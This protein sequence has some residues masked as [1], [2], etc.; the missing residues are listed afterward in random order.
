MKKVFIIIVTSLCIGCFPEPNTTLTPTALFSGIL[1]H[2]SLIGGSE[3]EHARQVIEL[4]DGGIAIVGSTQSH[5]GDFRDRTS[6]DWDLF[7]LKMDQQGNVNWQKN[8]G[9]SG[10]D[11]GYSLEETEEGGFVL[12]GYSNSQDGDVPPTNGFH[13]N[14]IIKVDAGGNLVWKKTFGFSGHDHA[15][16][17]ISTQDGGYFFNGFLD[18]TASNGA[19]NSGGT[20]RANR[21]GVGEF[22]CHK[23]DAQGNVEWQRY[24]GGTNNDRSYDALQ[25]KE[26]NFLVVGTSESSDV[27][28]TQPKGSYDIWVVMISPYGNL[29][30]ENS[31]GGSLVDGAS[32]VIQDSQGNFRIIGNTFSN[33][34]QAREN[35]GLSDAW[36]IVIDQSGKL[37]AS[38]HYGGSEFDTG[39]AIG[40]QEH[41]GVF[42]TGHSRSADGD[43]TADA[44]ENDLFLMHIL[45]GDIRAKAL[46]LGGDNDDFAYDL[47]IHSSGSVF[48]VGQ[49]YSSVI[50][51]QQNRGKGDILFTRWR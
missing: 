24:F 28:V 8:Y 10:D 30:W 2:V 29:L 18:V 16:K 45:S 26:G 11:F 5:D 23:L 14:W 38:H 34:K 22:W 19:G 37:M 49:T 48:V 13:D 17:V 47:L 50:H 20:L 40:E 43:F 1:S 3:D 46:S 51:D 42:I 25:T 35:K 6:D 12:L 41:G 7:L 32:G 9:G 33:D 31:Y 36:Q 44:G 27:E 39:T 15:Y 4:R 21:H